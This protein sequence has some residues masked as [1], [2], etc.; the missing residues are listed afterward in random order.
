M[1]AEGPR[2]PARPPARTL[3]IIIPFVLASFGSLV[4]SCGHRKRGGGKPRSGGAAHPQGQGQ[5]QGYGH[6]NLWADAVLLGGTSWGKVPFSGKLKKYS[7]LA[8]GPSYRRGARKMLPGAGL[9]D[10]IDNSEA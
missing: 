3:I 8:S 1:A 4:L 2:P 6:Y 5:G 9:N 7:F 10:E